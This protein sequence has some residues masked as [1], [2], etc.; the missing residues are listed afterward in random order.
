MDNDQFIESDIYTLTDE[1]GNESEYQLIGEEEIDGQFYIALVPLEENEEGCY[2]ILKRSKDDDGE[3]VFVTI[4]DDDEFDRIADYF[5][6]KLMPEID[7]DS[8]D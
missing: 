2:V 5:D 4:D 1:E 7:Y 6:D 3:D 8:E